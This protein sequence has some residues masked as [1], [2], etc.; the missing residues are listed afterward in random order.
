MECFFATGMG[1]SF[2]YLE[3]FLGRTTKGLADPG[4]EAKA[5]LRPIGGPEPTA[6]TA[7]LKETS[8]GSH[9]RNHDTCAQR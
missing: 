2:H 5:K 6:L 1:V 3:G 4:Y 9:A 8:D 7:I